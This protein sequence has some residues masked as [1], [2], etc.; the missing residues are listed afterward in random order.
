MGAHNTKKQLSAAYRY[1]Y[2]R[3]ALNYYSFYEALY[4]ETVVSPELK[5]YAGEF[6]QLLKAFVEGK[7]DMEKLHDLRVRVTSVMEVL[8]A[9]TDCFQIY[10]YVLNRMERRF[11]DGVKVDDDLEAFTSRLMEYLMDSKDTVI[12]NNRIQQVIGQLPVRYT[13]QKFFE[14]L[15][16]GLSVYIGSEKK[17]L[18]DML[19]I[20]RTISMAKLP[21]DMEKG[22]E[23]FYEILNLLRQADYLHMEKEEYHRNVDRIIYVSDQ[24]FQEA[25]IYMLLQ[26][27]INDL[28]V[29]HLASSAAVIEL[30]E[31][32]VL[33][34][35]VTGVLNQFLEG[36]TSMIDDAVTDLLWEL[37]GTQE[38][39]MERYLSCPA[40]EEN[41]VDELACALEKVDILLSGSP[42]AALDQT[43]EDGLEGNVDRSWLESRLEMLYS[44]LNEVF[45]G[46]SKPVMRAIMAR[47]LSSLPV[48][49]SSADELSDYIM[50][51]LTS[52]SDP[53]ERETTM[54][55]LNQEMVIEDALV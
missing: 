43:G 47:L 49:F 35:I 36:N 33:E 11:E 26:D 9:Y 1:S 39:A 46:T 21:E 30:S 50:R 44:E 24:L 52:C 4:E 10:E 18:E 14:L 3:M 37:E 54:E 55:L 38:S 16:D 28:Y 25:G 27:L 19:Y 41:P 6:N 15:R 48:V 12:M 7:G 23:D 53:A 32:Q 22:H 51:S 8:T 45:S 34:K 17:S 5:A 42:F 20:L 31:R 29:L 40:P 13:R 2:S